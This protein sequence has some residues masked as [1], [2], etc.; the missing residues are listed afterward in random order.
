MKG[1][2]HGVFSLLIIMFAMLIGLVSIM[3]HSIQIGLFY[4]TA[5]FL[6]PI[7]VIFSY[8][9]KCMCRLEDC[10]H[11]FPGK[12]TKLLPKRKVREYYLKDILGVMIPALILCGF[13]QYWLWKCK[14]LFFIFWALLLIGIAEIYLFVCK[15]CRNVNCKLCPK[16]K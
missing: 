16:N 2:F 4:I 13:P 14:P 10:G 8:C 1:K 12:I 11:V 3:L 5:L 9:S 7:V 15:K 6:L